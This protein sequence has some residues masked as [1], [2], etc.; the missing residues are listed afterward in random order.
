MLELGEHSEKEHIEIL[1][2][3][4]SIS[5][6]KVFLIGKE[7]GKAAIKSAQGDPTVE[8]FENSDALRERLDKNHVTGMTILVKGSRGTRLERAIPALL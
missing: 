5:A 2:L 7:F 4:L 3:A 8:L 6:N 1:S